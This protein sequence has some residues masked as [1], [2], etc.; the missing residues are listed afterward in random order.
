MKLSPHRQAILFFGI[1]L[2][3]LLL[4]GACFA[5][6]T[7]HA[8]LKSSHQ[9]KVA[10]LKHY[11]TTKT[12]VDQLE[13][14]LAAESRRDKID[15]WNSK[16]ETDVVQSLSANL[17][18]LLAKHEPEVLRQTEMGQMAGVGGIASKLKHPHT[19]MK[20]TFEGGFKPMQLLLAELET[21]MPQLV[22]ESLSITPMP[23]TANREK[24]TLQFAVVY[25]CWEG[26]KNAAAPR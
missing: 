17:E 21:E 20:L 7:G 26:S 19:R 18:R 11:Q 8:K 6:Y 22:L 5:A 16:L 23:A 12:G 9:E 15:Y 2:P 13:A 25:V 24:G 14:F 4:A 3:G 10:D 1:L